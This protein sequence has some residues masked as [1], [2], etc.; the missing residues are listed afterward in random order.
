VEQRVAFLDGLRGLA[1]VVVV[2]SHYLAAFYPG[3][4]FCDSSF[5]HFSGSLEQIIALSPIS[6]V[7]NGHFA[8]VIFFVLSGYVLSSSLNVNF[9]WNE[10]LTKVL[11]RYPRLIIPVAIIN[12]VIVTLYVLNLFGHHDVSLVTN[13]NSWTKEFWQFGGIENLFYYWFTQS[14]YATIFESGSSFN[15]VLW[16]IR[17]E[18]WGSLLVFVLLGFIRVTR[19]KV[20][21]MVL[22]IVLSFVFLD[23]S[24]AFYLLS[25]VVGIG[26]YYC[27]IKLKQSYLVLVILLLGLFLGSFSNNIPE[28]FINSSPWPSV[29][30][31]NQVFMIIL[32]LLGAV[33]LF[34]GILQS[35]KIQRFLSNKKLQSLGRYSFM[36]YLIH[37]PFLCSFSFWFFSCLPLW[38]GYHVNCL[39]TFLVSCVVLIIL[40]KFIHNFIEKPVL[41]VAR[42][43]IR[44]FV[45][46]LMRFKY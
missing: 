42:Y 31:S 41:V 18:F 11:Y 7:F 8:V 14:F 45:L 46:R 23:V 30:Y 40:A 44:V 25:F 36:L 12:V 43:L 9:S 4:I 29:F 22:F 16:T 32:H 6:F 33:F 39:V 27:Q 1:A 20:L 3:I 15:T 21:S 13:S 35:I 24:T 37:V 34:V 5:N 26:I 17:L 28:Q 2:L 38:F 10:L 19:L